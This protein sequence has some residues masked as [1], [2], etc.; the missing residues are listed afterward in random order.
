[1]DVDGRERDNGEWMMKMQ[2]VHTG[3]WGPSRQ[4]DEII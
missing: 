1:M 2:K 4:N 3:D